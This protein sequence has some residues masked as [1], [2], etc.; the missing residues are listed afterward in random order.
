[1]GFVGVAHFKAAKDKL[2]AVAIKD[3][4]GDGFMAPTAENIEGGKY[5][6]LSRPLF[7]YVK[8]SSLKKKHIAAFV[9]Y[10]LENPEYVSGVGYVQMS[11]GARVREVIELDDAINGP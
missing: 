6:P 5:T 1:M 7:I 4:G 8:K 10:Y 2:K 3:K 11:I 9:S